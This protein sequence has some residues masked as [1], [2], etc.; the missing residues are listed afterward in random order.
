MKRLVSLIAAAIFLIIATVLPPIPF[1][2]KTYDFVF[3][4]DITR[5]MNVQDYTD[6]YGGAITR[7]DKAKSAMLE[8]ARSLPCGSRVGLGVFT[9]RVPALLYS[10]IEVCKDYPILQASI[11]QLDWRMAWVADS[12]ISQG[13][14]NTLELM[15]SKFLTQ[16]KLVFFTD[17]QE[18]PPINPRYAPDYSYI[19]MLQD[20]PDNWYAGMLVGVGQ[21]NL[22]K[23]PKFDEDGVQIGFYTAE[24][25][26]H[27][28]RFGLPEDPSKIEGYV[29]RNGP[30]GTAKVV[31]TEHMSSVREDYLTDLGKKTKMTY[32]HLESNAGLSMALKQPY[33]AEREVQPT[34]MNSI[35]AALALLMLLYCYHPFRPKWPSTMRFSAATPSKTDPKQ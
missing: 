7:I 5:S 26:P 9:E 27:A 12:N 29:P 6:P 17:G 31:G 18:A 25:V 10:P 16:S 33:F 35:L 20:K 11:N 24:D 1:P 21:Y 15:E 19:G 23:I 28:S 13:L 30:W 2:V 8:A 3:V 32:H 4:L 14:Y 34:H 22:S